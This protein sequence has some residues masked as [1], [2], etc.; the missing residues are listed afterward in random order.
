MGFNK[1]EIRGKA[2]NIGVMAR[3]GGESILGYRVM[4]GAITATVSAHYHLDGRARDV[5]R[6]SC[7]SCPKEDL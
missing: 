6:G 7:G 3:E 4:C 5:P 2:T 1:R